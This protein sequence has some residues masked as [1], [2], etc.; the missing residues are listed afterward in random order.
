MPLNYK[1]FSENEISNIGI[2]SK[3]EYEFYVDSIIEKKS[4]GG[5]DKDGNPKKI[6]DM[7]EVV[8]IL[9]LPE[10]KKR[11]LKDWIMIVNEEDTFAFKLRH[12]AAACGLIE[13]YMDGSLEYYHFKSKRGIVKIGIRDSKNQFGEEIKQNTVLDYIK[14]NSEKSAKEFFNDEIL[15]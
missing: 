12:F 9:S 11:T 15:F 1:V 2:L 10:G 6:F 14:S 8:L 13:K 4:K 3:G 7:L 5:T